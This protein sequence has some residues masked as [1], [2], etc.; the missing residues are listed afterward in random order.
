MRVSARS[1]SVIG[2]WSRKKASVQR[3]QRKWHNWQI[4]PAM[5][6]RN[7]TAVKK[8]P[9][10]ARKNWL[11]HWNPAWCPQVNLQQADEKENGL[12]IR[13]CD[14]RKRENDLIKSLLRTNWIR[15]W[16]NRISSSWSVSVNFVWSFADKCCRK[17]IMHQQKARHHWHW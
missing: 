12:T 14:W 5:K 11:G 10:E 6:S 15:T 7:C 13:N 2:W 9:A 3:L 16:F 17:Y 4:N 1:E 8:I